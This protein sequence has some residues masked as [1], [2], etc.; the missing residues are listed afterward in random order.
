VMREN[1]IERVMVG[2]VDEM[3]LQWWRELQVTLCDP[4]VEVAFDVPEY[5]G[6]RVGKQSGQLLMTPA[7]PKGHCGQPQYHRIFS[8]VVTCTSPL[9]KGPLLLLAKSKNPGTGKKKMAE[10][11]RLSKRYLIVDKCPSGVMS[12]EIYHKVVRLGVLPR[13]CRPPKG[14]STGFRRKM[15]P[16]L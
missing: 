11:N 16:A 13:Y 3:P 15:L 1:H 5:R 6:L 7:K 14:G 4:T 9:V 2:N 10:L 8:T 12:G